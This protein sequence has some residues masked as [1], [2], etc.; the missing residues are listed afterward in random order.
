VPWLED[1]ASFGIAFT[2]GGTRSASAT[3]GEL[4]ALNDLGWLDRARY[5]SSNSGGSWVTVPYT[6]LPQ[7]IGDDR[8]LGE[9][10]PPSQLS[11]ANLS[12]VTVDEQAMGT[13]E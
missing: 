1:R 4:R 2:G 9:P 5:I 12:P 7:A 3:L 8:F 13:A 6:Y 10:I 11:D